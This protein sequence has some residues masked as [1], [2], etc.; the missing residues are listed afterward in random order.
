MNNIEINPQDLVITQFRT[1]TNPWLNCGY[2]GIRIKH[3][4]TGKVFESGSERSQHANRTKCFDMLEKWVVENYSKHTESKSDVDQ[5]LPAKQSVPFFG[6]SFDYS[7]FR[8]NFN[9]SYSSSFV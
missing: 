5:N 4:P 2:K 1:N 7:A 6:M 9:K 8:Q 3:I